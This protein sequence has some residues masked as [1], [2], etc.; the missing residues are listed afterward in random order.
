M[1][2]SATLTLEPR[3]RQRLILNLPANTPAIEASL[4]TGALAADNR[5]SLLP[6]VRKRIR[7]QNGF[8]DA[9]FRSLV[10]KALDSQCASATVVIDYY[11]F[12]GVAPDGMPRQY[13]LVKMRG[14]AKPPK[15]DPK[16][17]LLMPISKMAGMAAR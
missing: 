2:R 1:L 7:V 11:V 12:L 5:V 14:T 9:A 13:V 6:A 3:A 15:P 10:D 16:P 4:A 17:L 8:E